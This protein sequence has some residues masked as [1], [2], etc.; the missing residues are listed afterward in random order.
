MKYIIGA[1]LF[2]TLFS[3][4]KSSTHEHTTYNMTVFPDAEKASAKGLYKGDFAGDPIYLTINFASGK[5]VAGYNVHKG[6]RRNLSGTMQQTA[7]GWELVINEPGDHPFDGIFKLVFDSAFT[8][9][10]GEWKPLNVPSSLKEKNFTLARIEMPDNG[11]DGL[12]HDV[13]NGDHSDITF[14]E[15]GNCIFNYYDKINDSTFAEQM[16]TV[17]GTWEKKDTTLLV[18]WHKTAQW[19]KDKSVFAIMLDG[20]S[21]TI[22][23]G[24][25]YE[26]TTPF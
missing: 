18:T 10:K 12:Y 7:N 15:D 23:T 24:E 5:H 14:Q 19:D 3:R 26:F 9:A 13:L 1:F 25:G 11:A 17:R 22:V 2:I 21:I 16:N 6:L 8:S 4:C 20:S